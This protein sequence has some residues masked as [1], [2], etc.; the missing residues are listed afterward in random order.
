MSG[1]ACKAK[2]IL[3]G[4]MVETIIQGVCYQIQEETYV[5]DYDAELKMAVILNRMEDDAFKLQKL[6]LESQ[7]YDGPWPKA[8]S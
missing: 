7:G 8:M 5:E 1:T 3:N 4:L 6:Y 2:I